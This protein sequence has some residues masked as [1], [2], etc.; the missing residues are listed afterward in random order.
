VLAAQES[1]RVIGVLDSESQLSSSL[2]RI[3]ELLR[4][5]LRSL[6]GEDGEP[7]KKRIPDEGR[8]YTMIG[9]QDDHA[10]ERECELARLMKENEDLHRL[11]SLSKGEEKQDDF[12]G[13][14]ISLPR[15][16]RGGF[17]RRQRMSGGGLSQFGF[18]GLQ[19]MPGW[20][21]VDGQWT[22]RTVRGYTN[23]IVFRA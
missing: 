4:Q 1:A 18:S 9:P 10:L 5:A 13:Q 2:A 19:R 15:H 12:I 3:S 16:G 6:N 8:G 11:I 23:P 21:P 22:Q 14:Q 20:S 17:G 7:E